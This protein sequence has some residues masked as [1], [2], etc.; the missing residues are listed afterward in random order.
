MKKETQIK[1]RE[2]VVSVTTTI[3]GGQK[4]KEK[5]I[6]IRPFITDTAMMGVKLGATIPTGDYASA[7]IDVSV[8]CP[9]YK[10]EAVEMLGKCYDMADAFLSKKVEMIKGGG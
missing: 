8:F 7:R 9:C 4:S 10:E 2:A 6:R 3:L 1:Q 5:R